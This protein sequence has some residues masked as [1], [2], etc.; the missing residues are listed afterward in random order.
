VHWKSQ[1][2]NNEW[3]WIWC[4]IMDEDIKDFKTLREIYKELKGIEAGIKASNTVRGWIGYTKLKNAH[5]MRMYAKLGAVPYKIN[6]KDDNLWFRRELCVLA[7][8]TQR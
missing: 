6:L 7:A 1:F 4:P 5:I 2:I 3:L 8:A